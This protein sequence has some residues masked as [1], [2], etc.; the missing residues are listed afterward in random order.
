MSSFTGFFIHLHLK[1]NSF[2]GGRKLLHLELS[3][4]YYFILS[5]FFLDGHL[6]SLNLNEETDSTITLHRI[7]ELEEADKETIHL[8]IF[9]LMQFL[10]RSDQ[11]CF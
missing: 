2:A 10:S 6:Y 1:G 11:A 7:I 8:L 9:L 4:Q 3:M 5:S